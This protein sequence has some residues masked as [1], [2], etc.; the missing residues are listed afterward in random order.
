MFDLLVF[1]VDD[2]GILNEIYYFFFSVP[3]SNVRNDNIFTLANN[4][5]S[6]DNN[7]YCVNTERRTYPTQ[8]YNA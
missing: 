3:T 6:G 8:R 4:E 1:S 7:L 5:I 2:N